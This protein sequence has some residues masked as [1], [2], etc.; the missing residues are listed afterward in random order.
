[1]TLEVLENECTCNFKINRKN[2]LRITSRSSLNRIKGELFQAFS[3]H[4]FL[5][6]KT[7]QNIEKE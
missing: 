3:K 4:T 5:I 1:M 7:L 6:N 2:S